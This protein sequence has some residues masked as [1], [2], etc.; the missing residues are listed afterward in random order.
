MKS[1]DG[2]EAFWQS[3]S[4][5]C[6]FNS[7][8]IQHLHLLGLD[9]LPETD[10]KGRKAI[11]GYK[12]SWEGTI[13]PDWD[14]GSGNMHGAAAAYIVDLC[15]SAAIMIHTTSEFW[16]PPLVA[17]VSLAI[18]MTYLHPAKIGTEI[19]VEVEVLK[20]SATTANLICNILDR[21]SHQLLASGTHMKAWIPKLRSK[22]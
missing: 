14:N 20:C 18:N 5:F 4:S 17:G 8:A 7:S 11:D 16:G 6:P 12:M 2:L 15:T 10:A 3:F 19:L 21:S 9:E 1:N 22:L 13:P